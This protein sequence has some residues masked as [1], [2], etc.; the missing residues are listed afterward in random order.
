ML[1]FEL[2]DYKKTA[3]ER[4]IDAALAALHRRATSKGDRED[5]AGYAFDIARSFDI[6]MSSRDLV[7]LYQERYLKEAW[8]EK[9]KRSIDCSNP[10]GFS[11]RAYCAARKKGK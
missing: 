10:K 5:L 8:S 3:K 4:A 11:Q 1:L 7:K 6:G 9:Y 2:F